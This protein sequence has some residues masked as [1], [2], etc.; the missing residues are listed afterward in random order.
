MAI[1][2]NKELLLKHRFWVMLGATALLALI[3]IGYLEMFVDAEVMRKK[4]DDD[5]KRYKNTLPKS[6]KKTLDA[7]QSVIDEDTKNETKIWT[8]AYVEEEPLFRWPKLVEKRFNFA[9]GYFARDIKL[10][11]LPDAKSWPKDVDE[12]TKGEKILHGAFESQEEDGIW[13]KRGNGKKVFISPTQN[14]RVTDD[15]RP[16]EYV[17]LKDIGPGK[18]VTVTYQKGRYFNDPL[19]GTEIDAFTKSYSDQIWEVLKTV[20][21]L[22]EKGKG[23]VQLR[24]WL[25]PPSELPT[26]LPPSGSFIR[27]VTGPWNVNKPLSKEAWIAQEDLWI[28]TEIY[29]MIAEANKKIS[30]FQGKGGKKADTPYT[31]VNPT[32]KVEL[33]LDPKGNLAFKI[34]NRLDHQ[35]ALDLNFRV[36][37]NDARDF[38]PETFR[39]SGDA[40]KPAGDKNGKDTFTASFPIAKSPRNGVFSVQQVLTWQTAA[41]KRIDLISIG[42]AGEQSHSHRT[43][44]E[45]ALRPFDSKDMDG[46]VMAKGV[47]GRPPGKGAKGVI[48]PPK[49]GAAPVAAGAN[50][51]AIEHGLWTFR[52]VGDG[53]SDQFRRIPVAVVIIV[54]QDHVDRVLTSFNNS[55]LRFLPTQVLLN[56]YPGSLQPPAPPAADADKP[57]RPLFPG[58]R[59]A[60][61]APQPQA[62]AAS[63]TET[64]MELIIY[65]IMTLYQRYPPLP[66][67]LA[68]EKKN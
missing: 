21:P 2:F 35:Q 66:P 29:R 51:G 46:A 59:P 40:L 68:V 56:Q 62:G 58:G 23:V 44:G 60:P 47:P 63:D 34:K 11:K 18:F 67:P 6:N 28:Q 14:V 42:D 27:Y 31:F 5:F 10:S 22:D 7:Y 38:T 25:Y 50:M 3:G 17:S 13:V 41:V 54:D 57:V 36:L 16:I 43:F 52:Y 9:N 37:L 65:G 30:D 33:T 8:D 26:E 48:A 19:T 55:K 45:G 4:Y 15:G 64:N 12:K 61:V 39:I 53:V 1:K 49:G 20:E 32:F 24:D